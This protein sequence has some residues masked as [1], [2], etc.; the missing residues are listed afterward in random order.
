M[1]RSTSLL[2][3]GQWGVTLIRLN[4]GSCANFANSPL[5][6]GAPLSVFKLFGLPNKENISLSSGITVDA[7]VLEMTFTTG[8]LL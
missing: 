3:C 2:A 4:P 7:A 5:E 8:N 6:N 1:M